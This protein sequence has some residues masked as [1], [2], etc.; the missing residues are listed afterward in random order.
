MN[1]SLPLLNGQASCSNN[2][3]LSV[4]ESTGFETT[5]GHTYPDP[6]SGKSREI[7]IHAGQYDFVSRGPLDAMFVVE[8]IIECKNSLN[9]FVLLGEPMPTLLSSNSLHVSSCNPLDLDF[10]RAS[11]HPSAWGLTTLSYELGCQGAKS[12]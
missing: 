1:R 5:I 9:P 10:A 12:S 7:D 11:G 2:E 6:E 8:L 3:L 4:C